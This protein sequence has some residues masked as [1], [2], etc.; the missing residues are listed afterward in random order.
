MRRTLVAVALAACGSAP[1]APRAD[2][3]GP[4]PAPAGR[5]YWCAEHRPDAE[6]EAHVVAGA[7]AVDEGACW[8]RA[9][10]DPTIVN[11]FWV[12]QVHC[13]TSSGDGESCRSTEADCLEWQARSERDLAL[14]HPGA[15]VEACHPE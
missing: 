1:P 2:Q 4:A 3:T 15:L 10:D 14:G 8:A 12:G 9:T 13:F 6:L 5:G 7:C 11:C